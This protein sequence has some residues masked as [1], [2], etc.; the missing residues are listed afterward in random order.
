MVLC[1]LLVGLCLR[2][3]AVVAKPRPFAARA[4]LTF[5][6]R[7]GAAPTP[8][9]NKFLYL[10]SGFRVDHR[11]FSLEVDTMLPIVIGDVLVTLFKYA[12][13][14]GDEIVLMEALNGETE[15]GYYSY[16]H[17]VSRYNVLRQEQRRVGIGLSTQLSHVDTTFLGERVPVSPYDLGLTV[18]LM[19][20]LA[21]GT[22]VALSVDAGN[23]WIRYS[24]FNPYFSVSTWANY[25]LRKP[26]G[27]FARGVWKRQRLDM[28]GYDNPYAPVEPSVICIEEWI[29]LWSIEA[30]L[31]LSF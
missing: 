3:P 13:G 8:T 25:Q 2:S 23:G 12:A 29:D 16:F 19:Q 31:S 30:G 1:A 20:H 9:I 24:S 7:D 22:T 5:E 15:P 26:V 6:Y 11:Y 18:E 17:L 4:Q 10:N 28:T 27:L 14:G 21:P